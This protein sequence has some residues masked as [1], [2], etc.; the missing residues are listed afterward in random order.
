MERLMPQ[1]ELIERIRKLSPERSQLLEKL[2]S[3]RTATA[4]AVSQA[5]PPA[6][7]PQA[8]DT[9]VL[10]FA[11]DGTGS[12]EDRTK[13]MHRR[14]YNAVTTQLDASPFGAFSYFLNYGYV[15]DL[16]PQ[17]AAVE[18]PEHYINRNSVKLVLELVGDCEVQGKRVLD[19]GCG[20]GGTVHAL[21]KFFKPASVSGVDL[22][23]AAIAFC[24]KTHAGIRFEEGDAER[25]P[26][27]DRS[28]DLVT[29]VESS[30]AYPNVFA[31][32]NEVNRVLTPGGC[33]LYTDVLPDQR[34]REGIDHFSSMGMT[35]ERDDDITSNVLLSC[36]QVARTRVGA[37]DS[38][39]DPEL[40]GNFLAVPGSEVYDSMLHR[41][42]VYRILRFRAR[43]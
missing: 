17:R 10:T 1:T 6:P 4:P 18:L 42:W 41:I 7:V 22:S 27:A 9:T 40:M 33:F 3:V 35:L 8:S 12:V 16:N 31:F 21:T 28:F 11:D 38:V 15:A 20:R 34:W 30:H 39:N 13:A 5:P 32:Y 43:Q 2:K 37:F 19:V 25:L 29:N 23:S 26:F 36:D 14:F 24:K